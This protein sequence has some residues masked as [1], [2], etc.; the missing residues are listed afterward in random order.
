M[1]NKKKDNQLFRNFLTNHVIIFYSMLLIILLVLFSYINGFLFPKEQVMNSSE[2]LEHFSNKVFGN[3]YVES[4]K[5]KKNI[6]SIVNVPYD[7]IIILLIDSLRFDFTLYDPNYEKKKSHVHS[8]NDSTK[9]NSFSR[10]NENN[11]TGNKNKQMNEKYL[12]LNNMLNLH[13]ILKNE[14]NNAKLLRFEADA[15]TVTT[16][17]V[18]SMITGTLPNYMDINENFS[19]TGETQDNIIDQ[20]HLNNKVTTA[21]GDNTITRLVKNFFKKFVYESFNIYDFYTLDEKAIKHF[22]DE[23]ILNYWDFMYVHVLSVDHIGHIKGPNTEEMRSALETMD[24]FIYDIVEK[25]KLEKDTKTLLVVFGD[26]GQMDT[27]DHGGYS[28]NEVHSSLF[29]YSQIP[30]MKVDEY[31]IR[32]NNFV[33]YDKNEYENKN[34]HLQKSQMKHDLG[35][36]NA[37]ESEE[38][39]QAEGYELYHSCLNNNSKDSLDKNKNNYCFNRT[40]FYN[41]KHTKQIHLV[42]TL[43]FLIGST[44]P[45][46]NIGY[47][48][49]DMLPDAYKMDTSVNTN[50]CDINKINNSDTKKNSNNSCE[51]KKSMLYHEVLNLHYIA[52]L[53][54][55]NLWQI[56]RY[57]QLYSTLFVIIHNNDYFLIK[58][59]WEEI[60]EQKSFFFSVYKEFEDDEIL[61][62]NHKN[63]Y[64]K[65]I[66]KMREILKIT[67]KYF[68]NIFT[69]KRPV[70]VVLCIFMNIFY[71]IVFIIV[72]NYCKLNYYYQP[73]QHKP[74][75]IFITLTLFIVLL[76]IDSLQK[77]LYILLL[78]TFFLFFLIR[79]NFLKNSYKFIYIFFDYSKILLIFNSFGLGQF[80]DMSIRVHSKN[81]DNMQLRAY[82]SDFLLNKE[83]NSED[84]GGTLCNRK[85]IEQIGNNLNDTNQSDNNRN[86][87]KRSVYLSYL[88]N[89]KIFN[90]LN[91]KFSDILY[92]HKCIILTILWS[93]CAVSCNY[94]EFENKFIHFILIVYVICTNSRCKLYNSAQFYQ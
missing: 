24:L 61:L 66:N 17:R 9:I 42:S 8:S 22:Y 86:D 29:L 84:T 39:S 11:K 37:N 92:T 34:M 7:K 52:E 64:T 32:E 44:V 47:V 15:P 36:S 27:G 12:F 25:I 76:L 46:S 45:F 85:Y 79:F 58:N 49:M 23:Y 51:K 55:A 62:K 81:D 77:N 35:S 89:L 69:L 59:G 74:T 26:H 18:K 72:Y 94:I 28:K 87:N 63:T 53:N 13:N 43:S 31:D 20:L 60:K 41:V 71:F 90:I 65:Y 19:L 93:S 40:Y 91:N 2:R 57:L 73:F 21:I 5:H 16:S 82:Q 50:G 68:Y 70:F 80:K 30:F 54:Y 3:E 10:G 56:M 14:K 83:C 75:L 88:Y 48:I 33:L 1:T 6:H 4:I 38:V 78:A 67:N